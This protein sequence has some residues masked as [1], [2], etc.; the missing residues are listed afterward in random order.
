MKKQFLRVEADQHHL[1]LLCLG[2]WT[3]ANVRGIEKELEHVSCDKKI[4]FD[5]S[6][7]DDFDS[8][9]VLL[10]IEYLH[11]FKTETTV[12]I[13]GYSQNQKD[14]YDLLNSNLHAF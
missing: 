2:Q 9:G 11:R 4:I 3:L 14:M 13:I 5:L 1:K 12:E 7:V 6:Y 10:F 8:A